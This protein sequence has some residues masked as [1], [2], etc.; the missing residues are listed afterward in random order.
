MPLLR[1]RFVVRRHRPRGER[2]ECNETAAQS[3][4]S[5]SNLLPPA[6]HVGNGNP[7]SQHSL[8]DDAEVTELLPGRG[9]KVA[10]TSNCSPTLACYCPRLAGGTTPFIRRYSTTWP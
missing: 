5:A 6:P 2:S 10:L 8:S 1:R 4:C 7:S 9:A 3:C